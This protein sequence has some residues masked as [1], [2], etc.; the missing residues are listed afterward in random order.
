M[1]RWATTI[2]VAG[3]DFSGC[4]GEIINGKVFQSTVR[5][6]V[7]W[8]A[9]GDISTQH[10]VVG[11]KGHT[12]G[13]QM[14]SSDLTKVD[15][16]FTAIDAAMAAGNTFVV[17]LI[18]ELQT[19]NLNCIVNYNEDWADYGQPAQGYVPNVRL[20]FISKSAVS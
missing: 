14:L 10:V 3:V 11:V 19:I 16:M 13:L 2:I 7:D 6:S 18:D 4:R 17:N 8:V 20:L 15:N 5:G 12:F 9:G 1:A